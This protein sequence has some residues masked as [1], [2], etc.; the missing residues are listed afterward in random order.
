MY[1]Y[2]TWQILVSSTQPLPQPSRNE[3]NGVL[4]QYVKYRSA[5]IDVHFF[6]PSTQQLI[7][8]EQPSHLRWNCF[9]LKMCFV[10]N[11]FVKIFVFFFVFQVLVR[12]M[13]LVFMVLL[14]VIR[15]FLLKIC[16]VSSYTNRVI[17][18]SI[19][20]SSV[21]GFVECFKV[22]SGINFIA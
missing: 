8:F 10:F 1:P 6:L 13:D 15:W 3:K 11:S 21:T 2:D 9:C 19:F 14:L 5:Y 4:I 17:I 20:F 22:C 12:L 18:C 7:S 16:N